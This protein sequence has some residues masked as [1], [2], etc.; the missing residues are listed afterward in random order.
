MS[1][2]K[3]RPRNARKPGDDRRL[4]TTF[5]PLRYYE[6]QQRMVG[7]STWGVAS[8]VAAR[9][10]QMLG[11]FARPADLVTTLKTDPAIYSAMLN[12]LAPHRGLPR[13][14]EAPPGANAAVRTE[15]ELLFARE[16]V[17]LSLGTLCDGFELESWHGVAVLS[18]DWAPRADG[19]R[20]DPIVCPWPQEALDT[21]PDGELVAILDGGERVPVVHGD[22]KWIVVAEHELRPHTWGALVPLALLFADRQYGVRDRSRSA[23]SHGDDKWIGELPPNMTTDSPQAQ[24]LEDQLLR[25]YEARRALVV[26]N[27]TKVNRS[28]A[29]GQNWQIFKE[30]IESCDRDAARILLGQDGSM[31]NS[32]GNYIKAWG[33]FGVRN[34]I[35]EAKLAAMSRAISTGLL[36][37]WSLINF[38]RWD[39]LVF[40]WLI[41]DAD[42]DTRR[43]SLAK[44][45]DDFLRIWSARKVAG[46]TVTQQDADELATALGI[47]A[48][49]I[50]AAPAPAPALAATASIWA[51]GSRGRFT[52]L[53]LGVSEELPPPNW[54][55]LPSTLTELLSLGFGLWERGPLDD[56]GLVLAR[57]EALMLIPAAWYA[58]IPE[59]LPL[60]SI[61]GDRAPFQRGVTDDDQRFGFLA[62][63]IIASEPFPPPAP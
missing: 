37:P 30:L 41:P 23:E 5:D 54:D 19:T 10:D 27:E 20:L 55:A 11:H 16:S 2:T 31:T 13:A 51:R 12:L 38:G 26:P 63:G 57:G 42:E 14:V 62:W 34:D 59:G 49:R 6:P 50:A 60:V 56:G 24:K 47:P 22:G 53:T 52:S 3:K 35:V 39:K 25:L 48:P 36:R 44:R 40:R 1:P 9:R 43:E 18:I 61:C 17:A 29:T 7:V 4:P 46:F 58:S 15:A 32:G 8:I 21:M 28:E 33:L 45:H